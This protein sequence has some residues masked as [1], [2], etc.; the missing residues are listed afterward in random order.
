MRKLDEFLPEYSPRFIS[1]LLYDHVLNG[2]EVRRTV[3]DQIQAAF[4]AKLGLLQ[5]GEIRDGRSNLGL[6][7]AEFAARLRLSEESQSRWESGA[8]LQPRHADTLIRLYFASPRTR[9]LLD[10]VGT[11]PDFGRAVC[12]DEISGVDA[13]YVGDFGAG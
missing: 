10:T 12:Y 5:P 9:R 4:R 1:E 2:G 8:L 7:Q 11:S 3:G 6:S 13:R